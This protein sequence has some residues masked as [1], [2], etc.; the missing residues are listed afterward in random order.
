MVVG[1][2][3]G[4]VVIERAWNRARRIV[5]RTALGRV[6]VTTVL[7]D[8]RP[9][10]LSQALPRRVRRLRSLSRRCDADAICEDELPAE[11]ALERHEAEDD[12]RGDEGSWKSLRNLEQVHLL[13]ADQLNTYDVL[14]SDDVVF[15]RGALEAFLARP[16][17]RSAKAVATESEASELA[18]EETK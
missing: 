17:G 9:E 15:T 13:T 3:V 5:A 11:P 1:S 7:A 14:V 2:V 12:E 4:V 10:D 6:S 16:A 8:P 18:T